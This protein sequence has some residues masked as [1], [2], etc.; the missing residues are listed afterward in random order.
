[1]TN[2]QSRL[3]QLL[4][5]LPKNLLKAKQLDV[6]EEEIFQHL[7]RIDP[8]IINDQGFSLLRHMVDLDFKDQ[9]H[10]SYSLAERIVTHLVN[11][12]ANPF[13]EEGPLRVKR[14]FLQLFLVNELMKADFDGANTRS[15]TDDNPFHILAQYHSVPVTLL[16]S[17]SPFNP[18]LKVIVHRWNNQL[19]SEGLLPI[20]CLWEAPLLLQED[21]N[22]S[23][24]EG[25]SDFTYRVVCMAKMIQHLNKDAFEKYTENS[26]R[27][28]EKVAKIKHLSGENWDETFMMPLGI[29]L[30]RQGEQLILNQATLPA[31]KKNKLRRF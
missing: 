20:E 12:G 8:N 18:A 6:L 26:W 13:G 24:K 10:P 17:L 9:Y 31:I 14:H 1:M 23:I 27:I 11:R 7:N 2:D 15:L 4:K 22:V 25:L 29:K 28:S 16:G 21:A 3:F 5:D 19:N 30:A